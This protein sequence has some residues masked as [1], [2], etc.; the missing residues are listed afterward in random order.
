MWAWADGRLGAR[1]W[2]TP[3]RRR[4]NI[5]ST[6]LN[7]QSREAEGHH[8][9]AT[10]ELLGCRPKLLEGR[11]KALPLQSSAMQMRASPI[12]AGKL[13]YNWTTITNCTP[14]EFDWGLL[15]RSGEVH[16]ELSSKRHAEAS[17]HVLRS[18]MS[19]QIKYSAPPHPTL[20]HSTP[21][22]SG[23]LASQLHVRSFFPT[24]GHAVYMAAQ[25][26]KMKAQRGAVRL[27]ILGCSKTKKEYMFGAQV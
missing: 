13:A 6:G 26:S 12:P 24:F 25:A 19:I 8:G 21:L 22:P 1:D 4:Q 27:I 11:S 10:H 14:P 17:L 9:R 15:G 16:D 5:F 7:L 2:T 20:L 18:Y 3:W 23:E